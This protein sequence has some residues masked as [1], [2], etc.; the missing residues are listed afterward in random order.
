[1]YAGR[2]KLCG[3]S[4]SNNF[5]TNVKT[6]LVGGRNDKQVEREKKRRENF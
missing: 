4:I 3:V 2:E 1:M 6:S 5:E